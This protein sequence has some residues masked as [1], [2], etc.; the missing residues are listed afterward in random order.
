[1]NCQRLC[2]G[3]FIKRLVVSHTLSRIKALALGL[4]SPAF[5]SRVAACYKIVKGQFMVSHALSRIKAL[6][7]GLGTP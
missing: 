3:Q 7:L 4:G 6:T 5:Q 2:L 1:M